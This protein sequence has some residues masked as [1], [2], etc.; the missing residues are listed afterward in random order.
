MDLEGIPDQN[1][2][3]LIGLLVCDGEQS[4][5]YSFWADTPQDEGRIWNQFLE[6]ANEYPEAPIYHY[7]SYEPRAIEQLTARYKTNCETLKKRLVNINAFIYGKVYFPVRSNGL[8]DLSKFVGASWTAPDA[9]GL[10]SLV[11]R[12]H[13]EETRNSEHQSRLIRYNEEDCRALQLLTEELSKIQ[14]TADSHPHI[15]FANQPKKNATEIGGQIHQQ[16]E[17]ILK[18][19]HAE[20][21]RKKISLRP[22][23]EKE[24]AVPKK[25]GAR[26]GHPGHSRILPSK[27]G[28]VIRVASRLVI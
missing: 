27:A 3:Y 4:S 15:D 25:R 22:K 20:H 23:S 9:S 2:H 13:W 26:Q 1:F 5:Y 19:A 14:T 16:F 28:K 12:H 10:Q 6:K 18:S 8:K 11:W 7:G 24:K 21:A 17:Q